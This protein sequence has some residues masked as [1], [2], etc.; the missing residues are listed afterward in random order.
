VLSIKTYLIIN[1]NTIKAKILQQ[2]RSRV[3]KLLTSS[4]GVKGSS[5]VRGIGPASNRQKNLKLRVSLLEQEKLLDTAIDIVSGI[6]PGISRIMLVSIRPGVR[7]VDLACTR[8]N[9]GKC[10]KNMGQ[11]L[12]GKVLG[13]EVATVNGLV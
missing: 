9:V 13:L 3:C 2:L 1:I 11:P 5:K 10:I 8:A 7:Q 12:S 6:I 4:L